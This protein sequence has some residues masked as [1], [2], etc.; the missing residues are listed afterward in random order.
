MCAH[1][2]RNGR[3]VPLLF[4]GIS[5]DIHFASH[6]NPAVYHYADLDPGFPIL[7]SI[8]PETKGDLSAENSQHGYAH[9]GHEPKRLRGHGEISGGK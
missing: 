2:I 1:S 4:E 8:H 7:R 3:N 6:R 9:R 5:T